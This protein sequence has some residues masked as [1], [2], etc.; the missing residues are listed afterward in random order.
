MGVSKGK[1]SIQSGIAIMQE[2]ELVV[3]GK[4]LIQEFSNYCYQKDKSD[5]SLGIPIDDY[6][7]GIDGARYFFMTR[8]SKSSNNY[9]NLR[10]VS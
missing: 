3:I 9:N 5:E 4:N 2:F 1:G 8:L 6:N 10:W 7:H